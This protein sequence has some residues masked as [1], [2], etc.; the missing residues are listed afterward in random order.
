MVT[1]SSVPHKSTGT[2][3]D[4]PRQQV[5]T[6]RSAPAGLH[7]QVCAEGS[8]LPIAPVVAVKVSTVTAR[9]TGH[10]AGPG[11]PARPRSS[12]AS[13]LQPLDWFAVIVPT[14]LAAALLLYDLG[15]R[16]LWLD[17]ADTFTTASQHGSALWHWALNDG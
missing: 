17:E 7:Q 2:S 4:V 9:E 8:R 13:S 12:G 6:S 14:A 3:A 10:V 16:S 11:H 5:C 15:G 1:E